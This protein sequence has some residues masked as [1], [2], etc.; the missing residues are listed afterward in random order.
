MGQ[1][2]F[3]FYLERVISIY[4]YIETMPSTTKRNTPSPNNRRTTRRTANIYRRSSPLWKKMSP[5]PQPPLISS[6][7]RVQIQHQKWKDDQAALA[8]ATS[9]KWRENIHENRRKGLYLSPERK[10]KHVYFS[11]QQPSNFW[12]GVQN[13]LKNDMAWASGDVPNFGG[14]KRSGSKRSGSKRSGSKR[15]GSKRSGSKRRRRRTLH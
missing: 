5:Q 1:I 13:K 10:E 11:N 3:L 8:Q 12:V 2:N 14:S 7:E 6:P 9:Q 15:S 4:Y